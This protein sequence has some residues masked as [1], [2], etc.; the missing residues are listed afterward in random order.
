MKTKGFGEVEKFYARNR[1]MELSIL[2]TD[3]DMASSILS[4]KGKEAFLDREKIFEVHRERQMLLRELIRETVEK[5]SYFKVP[6]GNSKVIPFSQNS[7]YIVDMDL[8]GDEILDMELHC[9]IDTIEDGIRY[10]CFFLVS[11]VREKGVLKYHSFN[12]TIRG[13]SEERSTSEHWDSFSNTIAE[14]YIGN[15][16]KIVN[17]N[18]FQEIY[19]N[20]KE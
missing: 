5:A 10:F 8:E 19:E 16:I 11:F 17:S 3:E 4:N 2:H 20:E 12:D 18:E 14:Q 1:L 7:C 15:I 6:N 13:Y 9:Y